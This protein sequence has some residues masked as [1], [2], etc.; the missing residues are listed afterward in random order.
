MNDFNK[1]VNKGKI[2]E[3][4]KPNLPSTIQWETKESVK[5]IMESTNEL[6]KKTLI[7]KKISWTEDIITKLYGD[8]FDFWWNNIIR[9]K[10]NDNRIIY[11]NPYR[12][13]PIK[14]KWTNDIMTGIFWSEDILWNKVYKIE[15]NNNEEVL[16]LPDVLWIE[17]FIRRTKRDG[18][19]TR[20]FITNFYKWKMVWWKKF[21][22][23][24]IGHVLRMYIDPITLEEKLE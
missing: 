22:E 17:K 8:I 2:I 21:L 10:I 12:L 4:S 24:G 16:V 20:N 3:N 7:W 9:V 1:K 5:V 19:R 15:I 14:I 13:E 18:I 6:I 11:I 23:V